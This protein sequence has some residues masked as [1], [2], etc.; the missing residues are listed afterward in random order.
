MVVLRAV[1]ESRRD[2]VA[3]MA[4]AL[5]YSLFLAIP[6]TALVVL[7]VFS[8]VADPAVIEDVVDRFGRVMPPRRRSSSRTASVVRPSPR[9]AASS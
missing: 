6:A 4:Q 9:G 1:E 8:L 7:G 2:G 3:T 5:A